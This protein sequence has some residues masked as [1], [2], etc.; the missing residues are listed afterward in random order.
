Q[1]KNA[2]L[3]L[4]RA[5]FTLRNDKATLAQIIQLDP[6]VASF[7]LVEPSWQLTDLTGLSLDELYTI[8]E[9]RRSDLEQARQN[10]KA[11]QFGYQAAKGGYFPSVN[12]FASYR[13]AYNYIHPIPGVGA[14]PNR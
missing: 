9:Q 10:E 1:V 4:L 8:A 3:L 14:T 6:S 5:R 12:A 7:E 13:S 2:E 11:A